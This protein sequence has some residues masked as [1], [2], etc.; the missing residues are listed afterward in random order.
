MD[1]C[2]KYLTELSNAVSCSIK[3]IDKEMQTPSTR[4]RGQKIAHI[5]NQL[6]LQNDIAI[7][8]GLGYSFKKIERI[9]QRL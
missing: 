5:T 6:E 8:F 1:E 3:L 9:K 7:R 4:K 2:K